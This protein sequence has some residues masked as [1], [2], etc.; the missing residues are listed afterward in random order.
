[1]Q[2]AGIGYN[3]TLRSFDGAI[4]FRILDNPERAYLVE[5]SFYSNHPL[6]PTPF[7]PSAKP[8]A[9]FHP[10]QTEYIQVIAGNAIVEVEGREILLSP[11]DGEF[12]VRAG[13]HHRLYPP[14]CAT[15][16]PEE[17]RQP[18]P[19]IKLTT[20]GQKVPQAFHEDV[21]FLENWYCYLNDITA[22]GTKIDFI[23]LLSVSTACSLSLFSNVKAGSHLMS[24]YG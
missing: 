10:Y 21:L 2:Y 17:Q 13:A 4:S 22:K 19:E 3:L 24:W 20:S 7:N 12:Q 1:M 5:V 9:H 16:I 8:P 11:E 14:Q 18:S 6:A 23:Q 15:T